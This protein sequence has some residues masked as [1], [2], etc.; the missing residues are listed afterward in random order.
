MADTDFGLGSL[1]PGMAMSAA[2]ALSLP[3]EAY[4]NHEQVEMLWA[5]KAHEFAEVHYNLLC[6]V[7]PRFLHLSPNDDEIYSAFRAAFPALPLQSLS[8]EHLKSPEAKEKW[9]S[10]CL[11]FEGR[12]DDFNF[13]TLLRL[14]SAE[15]YSESNTILATRIQFLA[16]EIARNREGLNSK[17]WERPGSEGG[18]V[19]TTKTGATGTDPSTAATDSCKQDL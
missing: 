18:A 10:F 11:E 15:P 4:G 12:V 8:H 17:H 3:A 9:R 19:S 16:V 1:G 2:D 13:G 7:D 6:S 5:M 14:E